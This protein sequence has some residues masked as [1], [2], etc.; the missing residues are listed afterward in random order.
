MSHSAYFLT[1]TDKYMYIRLKILLILFTIVKR[2]Y[3]YSDV[4]CNFLCLI[5]SPNVHV[6]YAKLCTLYV[7]PTALLTDDWTC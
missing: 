5:F 6:Q 1:L 2:I 3:R 7:H 4:Q